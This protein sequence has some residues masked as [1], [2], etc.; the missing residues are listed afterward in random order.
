[1][2]KCY[3]FMQVQCII[4]VAMS[5]PRYIINQTEEH[6]F[7]LLINGEIDDW[8]GTGLSQ[9]KEQLV[10]SGA[11][12]INLQINSP[13]GSVTEGLAIAAF[14]KSFPATINTLI[15]GLAASIATPIALAGDEVSIDRDSFFM[16]HNPWTQTAGEADDLRETADLLDKMRNQ[17]AKIYLAKIE[18]SKKLVNGRKDS[19]MKQIVLWMDNETWFTA[20]EAFDAGLVDKVINRKKNTDKETAKSILNKVKSFNNAPL[21]FLSEVNKIAQMEV[22][23]GASLGGFLNG[24][25]DDMETETIT[26]ADI[27]DSMASAAGI[28][29]STVGQ[30]L[31]GSIN[32][33]PLD[34]LEGFAEVLDVSLNQI[35]TAAEGDSCEYAVD[36]SNNNTMATEENKENSF[37]DK[38]KAL[39]KSNPKEVKALIENLE[40]D[41]K[42]KMK[43][44]NQKKKLMQQLNCWIQSELLKNL[45]NY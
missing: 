44:H 2:F 25:I 23:N 18:Q 4:I 31:N 22:E 34:R 1:M 30:I 43:R 38:V 32:C 41:E 40:E 21:A 28:S 8:W 33:P 24:V 35:I 27:I 11:N 20:Q 3:L 10:N 5:R 9:V 14:I 15:I 13:G 45:L 37:F 36:N 26:R 6:E 29:S 17:L 7:D 16:I 39:F 12:K 42:K 19:T